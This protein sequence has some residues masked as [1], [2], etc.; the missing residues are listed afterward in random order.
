MK[1]HGT[2]GIRPANTTSLNTFKLHKRENASSLRKM[3][4]QK[5]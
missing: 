2:K 1:R 5:D 4:S 3:F